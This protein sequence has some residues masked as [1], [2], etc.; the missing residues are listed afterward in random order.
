MKRQLQNQKKQFEEEVEKKEE[1]KLPHI[2]E[3][4]DEI[5]KIS[6]QIL[7]MLNFEKRKNDITDD[8]EFLT[9]AIIKAC[10]D[11]DL[12]VVNALVIGLKY[13]SKKLKNI[14]SFV[15]DLNDMIFNYYEFLSGDE[16]KDVE[17]N[18]DDEQ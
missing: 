14:H 3:L 7:S 1:D 18:E 13:A 8:V 9:S 11:G 15:D 4:F 5:I 10:Q 2:D 17:E 12:M 16:E 6:N